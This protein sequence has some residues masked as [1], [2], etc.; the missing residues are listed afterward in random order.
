MNRKSKLTI[1]L[2]VLLLLAGCAA[3]QVPGPTQT[4]QEAQAFKAVSIAFDAYDLGMSSL[5][6]LQVNKIITL[7]KYTSIKDKYAW[8]LYRAIVAA[9]AAAEAYSQAPTDAMLGKVTAALVAVADSQREF[10]K[11]VQGVQGSDHAT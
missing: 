7:T 4:S 10:T 1:I 2:V 8:P 6:M 3:K 5:R 9:Q 11:V